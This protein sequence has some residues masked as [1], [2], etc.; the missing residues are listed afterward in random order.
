MKAKRFLIF[1]STIIIALIVIVGGYLLFTPKS[2]KGHIDAQKIVTAIHA[3][4]DKL[5]SQNQPLPETIS[6]QQLIAQGFLKSEDVNAFNGMDVTVSLA[7]DEANPQQV[8]MR[9]K[10]PDGIQIVA[11]ADGSIQQVAK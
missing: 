11:L 1:G 3:Y 5:K 8:L 2:Q 10:M 6:L 9:A 7:I 4:N